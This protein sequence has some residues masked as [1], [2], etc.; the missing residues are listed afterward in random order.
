MQEI[1]EI[2]EYYCLEGLREKRGALGCTTVPI[3]R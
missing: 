3:A 1:G 2:K